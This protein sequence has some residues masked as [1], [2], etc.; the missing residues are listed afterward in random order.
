MLIIKIVTH[1]TTASTVCKD[2]KTIFLEFLI[3]LILTKRQLYTSSRRHIIVTL[4]SQYQISLRINQ[5]NGFRDLIKTSII[6]TRYFAFI[7]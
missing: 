6:V 1:I 2:Q 4:T 7:R 5:R 3:K